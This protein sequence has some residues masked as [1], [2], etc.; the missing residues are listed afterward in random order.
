MTRAANALLHF[1]VLK[2]ALSSLLC[3]FAL[4][5]ILAVLWL[6]G[7][8]KRCAQRIVDTLIVLFF[9]GAVKAILYANAVSAFYEPQAMLPRVFHFICRLF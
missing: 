3:R 8:D 4:C 1:H 2:H 9:I 6:F 5:G 7:K